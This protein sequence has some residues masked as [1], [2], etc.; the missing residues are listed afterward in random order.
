MKH[1]YLDVVRVPYI[2]AEIIILAILLY[3]TFMKKDVHVPFDFLTGHDYGVGMTVLVGV[4]QVI[5]N[6]LLSIVA[7]FDFE[8]PDF[9]FKRNVIGFSIT[10]FVAFFY[11]SIYNALYVK[12]RVQEKNNNV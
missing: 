8:L 3:I 12:R 5:C 4:M 10:V 2:I 7:Y 6:A 9:L 11:S 1:K